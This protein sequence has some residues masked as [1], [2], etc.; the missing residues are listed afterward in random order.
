MAASI[1]PDTLISSDG[2][3]AWARIRRDTDSTVRVVSLRWAAQAAPERA[4]AELGGHERGVDHVDVDALGGEPERDRFAE[5]RERRLRRRVGAGP[6]GGQPSAVRGDVDHRAAPTLDHGG[7]DRQGGSRRARRPEE[8]RTGVGHAPAS[9]VSVTAP[10]LPAASIGS[11]SAASS[12]PSCAAAAART[13]WPA[14]SAAR[15][16]RTRTRP[17]ASASAGSSSPARH[18]ERIGVGEHDRG[19]ARD[20]SS[21]SSVR[22]ARPSATVRTTAHLLD[23]PVGPGE[24]LTTWAT[25][26]VPSAAASEAAPAAAMAS[27][28]S[29]APSAASKDATHSGER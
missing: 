29:N 5:G 19:R 1:R 23:H 8:G 28:R 3:P 16:P 11:V 22:W 25:L 12:A 27:D 10:V 15:S 2:P 6:G 17:A 21:G 26:K 18:R 7:H 9:S 24:P 4:Q 13:S 20:R 14:T